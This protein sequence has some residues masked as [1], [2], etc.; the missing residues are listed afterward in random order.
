MAECCC[1]TEFWCRACHGE[2]PPPPPKQSDASTP[3]P[4]PARLQT[5]AANAALDRVGAGIRWIAS[6]LFGGRK[7]D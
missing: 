2:P 7:D 1:G 4:R 3:Y 5:G 6:R